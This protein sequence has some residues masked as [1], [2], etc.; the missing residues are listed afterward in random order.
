MKKIF[1]ALLLF[2]LSTLSLM[3]YTVD[4]IPNGYFSDN[5]Y[6]CDTCTNNRTDIRYLQVL[7]NADDRLSV[8]LTEDGYWG[9]NTKNA[10]KAFQSEYGLSADGHVGNGTKSKLDVVLSRLKSS[11]NVVPLKPAHVIASN[12]YYVGEIRISRYSTSGATSYKIYRATSSSKS[13][14]SRIKT[15]SSTSYY[16][17]DSSLQENRK[18]YYRVKACNDNGCSDLSDEYDWGRVKSESVAKPPKPTSISPGISSSTGSETT[19]KTPTLSWDAT[20]G[21]THYWVAVRDVSTNSLVLNKNNITENDLDNIKKEMYEFATKEAT[22]SFIKEK[23]AI[24]QQ[25]FQDTDKNFINSLGKLDESITITNHNITHFNKA[26]KEIKKDLESMLNGIVD[27]E[28]KKLS[29]E[30]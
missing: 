2:V 6:M 28:Y 12:D 1:V 20:S 16:D 8:S 17:D 9:N 7:L 10:V 29:E 26:K 5:G 24:I 4:D 27:E 11:N 18:Y 19:D 13:S 21:A 23:L 15:T 3:A 14:M 30:S 25:I 22:T